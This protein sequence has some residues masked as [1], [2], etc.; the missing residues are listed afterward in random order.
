MNSIETLAFTTE[1][2]ASIPP[3]DTRLWVLLEKAKNLPYGIANLPHPVQRWL[4]SAATVSPH[5]RLHLISQRFPHRHGLTCFICISRECQSLLYRF[6]FIA[7]EHLT[8]LDF[9]SLLLGHPCYRS[10]LSPAPL[11]LTNLTTASRA[12]TQLSSQAEVWQ[13]TDLS[14][15]CII[16]LPDGLLYSPSHP[17]DYWHIWSA[18]QHQRIY[19]PC[20]RGR[21]CHSA[22]TQRAENLLR[23]I[24]QN[25]YMHAFQLYYE[26][27]DRHIDFSEPRKGLL[28]CLDLVLEGTT[29]HLR[30]YSRQYLPRLLQRE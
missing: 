10:F 21:S 11:Y 4:A 9:A 13:I 24:S 15:P 8:R 18:H 27:G 17:D 6:H 28:H 2:E 20:Y 22:A 1:P 23:Q 7:Y 12:F 30:G 19:L 3:T 25:D 14:I 26:Q 5:C 29:H 16:Y